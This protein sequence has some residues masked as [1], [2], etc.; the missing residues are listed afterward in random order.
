MAIDEK[1]YNDLKE[2]INSLEADKK[3][4]ETQLAIKQADDAKKSLENK[5]M[6]LAQELNVPFELVKDFAS[7]S[8][9]EAI[10]KTKVLAERFQSALL[11]E[12][13]KLLKE[14]GHTPQASNNT[15]KNIY[16]RAEIEKMSS[17][18]MEKN[19]DKV[20]ASLKVLDKTNG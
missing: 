1:E 7:N 13:A 10:R 4:L 2:K 12:K 5:L 9:E 14:S 8:E 17:E 18:E 19:Y 11:D 3:K 20:I 15:E 16:T 6:V